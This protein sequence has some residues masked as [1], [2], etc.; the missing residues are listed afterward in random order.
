[1]SEM[2]SFYILHIIELAGWV[3]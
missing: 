2:M 1:M 3:S